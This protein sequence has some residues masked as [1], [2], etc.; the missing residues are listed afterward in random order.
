MAGG[1]QLDG[2]G[3]AKMVVLEDAL[4]TMAQIH[5]IVER[6]G[7]A[8]KNNQNT[9]LFIQQVKRLLTPL[10][11]KLKLQFG[12][13]SD[14]MA[15]MLLATTRGSNEQMRLRSLREHTAQIKTALEIAVAQTIAKHER[16]DEKKGPAAPSE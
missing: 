15:A 10:V 16:H 4:H 3:T 1:P 12:M 7:M 2:A 5:A 14:Q 11:T 9:S 8:V 6:L 13:I